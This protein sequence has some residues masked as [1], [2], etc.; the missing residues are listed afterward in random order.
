LGQTIDRLLL[1]GRRNRDYLESRL[2]EQ[3]LLLGRGK[4]RLD[5]M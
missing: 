1:F 3:E 5:D 2:C 4:L